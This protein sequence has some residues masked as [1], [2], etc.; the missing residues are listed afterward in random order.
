MIQLIKDI[1]FT[2]CMIFIAAIILTIFL[3]GNFLILIGGLAYD[4]FRGK[5]KNKMQGM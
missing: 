5:K 3:L 1:M 4:L 2:L